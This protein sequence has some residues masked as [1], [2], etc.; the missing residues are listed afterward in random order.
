MQLNQSYFYQRSVLSLS[1][2]YFSSQVAQDCN[3]HIYQQ[4]LFIA[5]LTF[6]CLFVQTSPGPGK[7]RQEASLHNISQPLLRKCSTASPRQ[8]SGTL[9]HWFPVSR[10]RL[11]ALRC[12]GRNCARVPLLTNPPPPASP[13]LLLGPNCISAHQT[14]SKGGRG[15]H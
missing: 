14:L 15:Q 2:S 11:Q 1:L 5:F 6:L 4:L 9:C 10:Q 12:P 3:P 8:W 7:T 13:A